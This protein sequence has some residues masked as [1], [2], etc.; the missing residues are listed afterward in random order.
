MPSRFS[1]VLQGS[2]AFG[3]A[4]LTKIGGND[5][6]Y[7]YY[8]SHGFGFV[9]AYGS[10]I[11]TGGDDI[12]EAEPYKLVHPGVGGHDNLRN[13]NFCQGAGW[14]QRGDNAIP[15]RALLDGGALIPFGTDA[16]VEP[17]DPWPGLAE[18]VVR[19]NP[20]DESAP[21]VGPRQA[22]DLARAL[23]AACLDPA[24]VAG[25]TDL[26]RLTVGARADLLVVPS[27]GFAEPT[28]AAALA[29]TRPLATLID[30]Q[31]VHRAAH[32]DP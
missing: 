12:Y 14:G 4:N 5:F 17:P 6:Y 18:A 21:R 30:C 10:L 16:P 7:A 23:R 1:A 19:R 11:D 27:A 3:V 25:L 13:Y 15:L 2:A 31:V 20:G 22:I 8:T 28:D 32:F 29:V 9:G 26:G 24:L